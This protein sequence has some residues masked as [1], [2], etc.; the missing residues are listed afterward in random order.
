AFEEDDSGQVDQRLSF[1]LR[2]A[3]R[4]MEVH[5]LSEPDL[6]VVHESAVRDQV[7][8]SSLEVNPQRLGALDLREVEGQAVA[9]ARVEVPAVEPAEDGP[10]AD[11]PRDLADETSR[12][13]CLLAG[14]F[15][16]LR[17]K[18]GDLLA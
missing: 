18:R 1:G 9:V 11:G 3:G 16:Q 12:H 8:G 5:G 17:Q 13:G 15:E 4:V 2:L 14:L 6:G 10:E 7:G